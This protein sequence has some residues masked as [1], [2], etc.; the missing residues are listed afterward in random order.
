MSTTYPSTGGTYD[1]YNGRKFSDY[2]I[3]IFIPGANGM[4]SRNSMSVN[5]G[6]FCGTNGKAIMSI[7]HDQ[8][9]SAK[10][11]VIVEYVSDTRFK[12]TFDGAKSITNLSI[13]GVLKKC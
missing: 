2:A 8:N 11:S 5:A 6:R 4:D 12:V 7:L 13:I 10:S 3:L 1:T 9:L